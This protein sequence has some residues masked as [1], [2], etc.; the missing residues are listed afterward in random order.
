MQFL[1]QVLLVIQKGTRSTHEHHPIY[2]FLSYH[3]LSLPYYA[4]V[5]SLP[6][7]SIPKTT[8]EAISHPRCH[9]AMLDEI[10][11][12]HSSGTRDL[13]LLPSRKSTVGCH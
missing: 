4:F 2:H 13:V 12:L 5:S 6:S 1:M 10:V 7:I 8:S 3:R 9:Q 11:V